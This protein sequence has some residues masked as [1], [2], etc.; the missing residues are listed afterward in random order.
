MKV[1]SQ[2]ERVKKIVIL[3]HPLSIDQD[4]VTVTQKIRRAAV[5]RRFQS[6][7]DALYQGPSE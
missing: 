5:F 6:Y 1:V 3:N 2:V 4:E 7:L